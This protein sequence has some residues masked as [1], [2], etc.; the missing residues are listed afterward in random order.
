MFNLKFAGRYLLHR[1]KSI[2]R[3]GLHSPFVYQLVDK[4]IYDFAD[5]KL[6][7]DI[8]NLINPD[9]KLT[10]VQKLLARLVD[11]AAPK[12]VLLAGPVA[13]DHRVILQS[14]AP[15]SKVFRL[16]DNTAIKQ[17]VDWIVTDAILDGDNLLDT[18][19]QC[20][21][22]AGTST[23]LLIVGMHKLENYHQAWAAIKAHP[24][25]T[26]TVD[27]FWYTL[28]YFRHGQVREDFL[29]RF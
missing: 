4:V 18:F 28:V 11:N 17:P 19:K 22:Y 29:I 13:T 24:Q 10:R 2:N 9:K 15:N 8:Q 12:N 26:V 20:M 16:N 1:F 6:Y 21:P 27:L 14:A 3:H 23:T 5:K 7:Q 25:V